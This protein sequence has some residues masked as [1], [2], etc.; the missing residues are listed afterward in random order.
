M[1]APKRK[2]RS[3]FSTSMY[4]IAPVEDEPVSQ[5]NGR[6]DIQKVIEDMRRLTSKDGLAW[7]RMENVENCFW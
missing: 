1:K 6:T 5:H 7:K 2:R 4:A 3:S